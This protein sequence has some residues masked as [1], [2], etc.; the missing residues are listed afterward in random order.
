[1]APAH[2]KSHDAQPV[3][4]G[5]GA[6]AQKICCGIHVIDD[7]GISTTARAFLLVGV[8]FPGIPVIKVGSDAHVAGFGDAA[9]H[10]L[11]K[12]GNAI[13]ILY[14]ND[15]WNRTRTFWLA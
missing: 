5:C 1:N 6:T 15:R 13:L 9:R 7:P 14:N 3:Y 11:R 8:N 12:L 10:L 2:A 4:V